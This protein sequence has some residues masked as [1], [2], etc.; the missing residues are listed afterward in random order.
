VVILEARRWPSILTTW[1]QILARAYLQ[2][3]SSLTPPHYRIRVIGSKTSNS[4]PKHANYPLP[5]TCHYLDCLQTTFY[6]T[7]NQHITLPPNYI[8]HHL[9]AIACVTSTVPLHYLQ[10]ASYV[11]HKPS[12]H[13]LK[14][15]FYI[16]SNYL[17]LS[18][19]L[20]YMKGITSFPS[21]HYLW[22]L[23]HTFSV[24]GAL[25]GH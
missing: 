12:L 22:G 10:N 13:C 14:T 5:P 3:V 19:T 2:G 8:L 16:T 4:H 11:F 1:V 15:T 20:L 23:L 24:R 7:L 17:V 18:P 9:K 6:I 25:K 21:P